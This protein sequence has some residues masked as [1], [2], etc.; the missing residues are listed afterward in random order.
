MIKNDI[1]RYSDYGIIPNYGIGDRR[2]IQCNDKSREC[3]TEVL[4]AELLGNC[5]ENKVNKITFINPMGQ[6]MHF[7]YIIK[8]LKESNPKLNICVY[9]DETIDEIYSENHIT[10]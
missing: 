10:Q 7:N 9:S 1:V 6:A 2:V 5:Y 4:Y 3:I 8:N